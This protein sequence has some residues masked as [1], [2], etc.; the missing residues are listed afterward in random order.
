MAFVNAARASGHAPPSRHRRRSTCLAADAPR[1]DRGRA[2]SSRVGL[3]QRST[4]PQQACLSVSQRTSQSPRRRWS[5]SLPKKPCRKAWHHL[6]RSSPAMVLV[7]L[8]VSGLR[9]RRAAQQS[10]R[11]ACLTASK[12]LRSWPNQRPSYGYTR[13]VGS[14]NSARGTMIVCTRWAC[15][16]QPM[17]MARRQ[18]SS[19]VRRRPKG[20]EA[21]RAPSCGPACG[22]R[23]SGR[24]CPFRLVPERGRRAA[25]A[26]CL[27][28]PAAG[29]LTMTVA[30][31]E[32]R[33]TLIEA[34]RRPREGLFHAPRM[35]RRSRPTQALSNRRCCAAPA[36]RYVASVAAVTSRTAQGRTTSPR[37]PARIRS[38]PSRQTLERIVTAPSLRSTAETCRTTSPR[39]GPAR[40]D[41]V[42]G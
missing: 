32:R 16:R 23:R 13:R 39:V 15:Q 6:P 8:I 22:L 9:Q 42:S 38:T 34:A 12:L 3:P 27:R 4:Q 17:R 29:L 14:Q 40:P 21:L 36:I 28:K 1:A 41:A 24:P 19:P 31:P 35:P 30:N 7:F 10:D 37:D 2:Q 25:P 20:H 5:A 33:L 18:L 26:R 11:A